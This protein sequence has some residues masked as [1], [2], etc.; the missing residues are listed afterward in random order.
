M[1]RRKNLVGVHMGKNN[2]LDVAWEGGADGFIES[3]RERDRSLYEEKGVRSM[4][5]LHGVHVGKHGERDESDRGLLSEGE[6]SLNFLE[7][8]M[9][10]IPWSERDVSK[11]GGQGNISL[12]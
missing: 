5:G 9:P 3:E 7:G 2:H 12:S 10:W 4:S 8:C 6:K 11:G 1:E